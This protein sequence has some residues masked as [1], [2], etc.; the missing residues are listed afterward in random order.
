VYP[1][2]LLG[3]SFRFFFAVSQM[4]TPDVIDVARFAFEKAVLPSR[5][6]QEA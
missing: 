5:P 1:V 3:V 4:V 2:Y 6:G